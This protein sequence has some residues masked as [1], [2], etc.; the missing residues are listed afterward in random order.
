MEPAKTGSCVVPR[1]KESRAR[2]IQFPERLAGVWQVNLYDIP[3]NTAR[4]W[5]SRP[6]CS[7][8]GESYAARWL[9]AAHRSSWNSIFRSSLPRTVEASR[10]IFVS[11]ISRRR[12]PSGRLRWS[13]FSRRIPGGQRLSAKGSTARGHFRSWSSMKASVRRVR[14]TP[15]S[16]WREHPIVAFL[17]DDVRLPRE[18]GRRDGFFLRGTL[19]GVGGFVDHP[20]HYNVARN[21][22]YRVLGITA[23]RYKIDWGGFN[24]GRRITPLKISRGVAER[25]QHVV[26]PLG[27]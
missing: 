18:L 6:A 19:G 23:G 22:M 15:A 4:R 10:S 27:N 16:R 25:W 24:V 1:A 26:P 21:A 14:A 2:A 13:S 17:D 11:T 3:R 20:G 8:S 7:A 12:R 9:P 5:L